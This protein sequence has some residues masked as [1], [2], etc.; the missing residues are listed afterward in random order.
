MGRKER[1]VTNGE[2]STWC[3]V[4]SGVPQGSVLGPLS[5]NIYDND[6]PIQ[7][8][9]SVLQFADDLKMFRV[10]QDA[11]DFQQ[12]QDDINK[13][14]AWANKWQLRFNT[15]KCFLLHL[16]P[17]HEY[18]EYNIQGTIISS[19]DTIKDLGV[20]IDDNLKFHS[21]ATSVISKANR[22]LASIRK[23][24][25][26]TD[27]HMFVTLYKSLVRPVIE[28][29]NII[30]GSHYSL[31]QQNIEKIQRRATRTLAGL[32]DTPYTERLCIL[33]LPSLQYR[34]LRGDMILLYCLVNNDIGIDFSDLY[35]LLSH[36][37]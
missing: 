23:T 22:T 35:H 32:K 3:N 27:N 5:F 9:S 16:G 17:P 34:R 26:F 13:L 15:S 7:V 36:F 19:C 11:Q 8:S 14:L 31:D 25:H 12:L 2:T 1:V 30:W 28:Y 37:Y 20:L 4:L 33:G 10:I 18:G 6:I 24:F 21:H 29:G